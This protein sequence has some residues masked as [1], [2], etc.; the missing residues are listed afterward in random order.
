MEE[1]M[2]LLS[3]AFLFAVLSQSVFAECMLNI[4]RTPCPGKE[5]E[6]KKPYDGKNPTDEKVGK[7]KDEAA[8]VAAGEKAAKIVRK[9]TLSKKLVKISFD[10]KAVGEKKDEAACN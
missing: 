2:K 7:A 5:A 1:K 8:C 10:G 4:D 3:L 9:G 6:A